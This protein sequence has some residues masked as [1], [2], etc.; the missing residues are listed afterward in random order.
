MKTYLLAVALCLLISCK[1]DD[2][3]RLKIY[4]FEDFNNKIE[5]TDTA[6]VNAKKRAEQDIEKGRISL[7]KSEFPVIKS[8]FNKAM[9]DEAIKSMDFTLDTVTP[10]DDRDENGNPELFRNDCYQMRMRQ[11]IVN[12]YDYWEMDSLLAI[13]EKQYVTRHN[14]LIYQMKDLDDGF[15]DEKAQAIHDVIHK[16]ELKFKYDFAYPPGYVS[17]TRKTSAVRVTFILMKDGSTKDIKVMPS[18]K[19]PAN[20]K[21]ASY[22]TTAIKKLITY[23]V[24]KPGYIAR[25]P[26]NSRIELSYTFK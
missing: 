17:D 26:V 20:N 24:W 15:K 5:L 9:V 25:V 14:N 16:I 11:Y 2:E 13:A 4:S 19:Y 1:D 7:L 12:K 8:F 10:P 21:Y 6:C 23:E 18:F 22:F 3:K